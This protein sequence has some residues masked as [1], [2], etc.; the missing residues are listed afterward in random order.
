VTTLELRRE[1]AAEEALAK[2]LEKYAGEWVATRQH[3]VI[4]H[5]PSLDELLEQIKT[6]EEGVEGI[7][8]VP[9]SNYACF[10]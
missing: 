2:K 5:A 3:E 8:Q 7:F 6:E 9:E 10:F 4:G 1:I